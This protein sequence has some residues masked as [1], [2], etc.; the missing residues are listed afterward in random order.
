MGTPRYYTERLVTHSSKSGVF[1]ISIPSKI[2]GDEWM[3]IIPF[4]EIGKISL[5]KT[6]LRVNGGI[7]ESISIC[8]GSSSLST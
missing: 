3:K 7:K 2:N 6:C 4:S 5:V 1:I 8:D